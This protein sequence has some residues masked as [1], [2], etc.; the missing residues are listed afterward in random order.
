MK[1]PRP[2]RTSILISII[3]LGLTTC[4]NNTSAL[5]FHSD[6]PD[7]AD[8]YVQDC[9][10]Y[11]KE[12]NLKSLSDGADSLEL[13]IW[14]SNGLFI[15]DDHLLLIK[16]QDGQQNAF[17]YKFWR[18]GFPTRRKIDSCIVKSIQLK[19]GFLDRLKQEKIFDLPSPDNIPNFKYRH[20]DG[21]TW[22]IE[23]ATKDSYRFYYYT[24]PN[25]YAKDFTEFA[26][27]VKIADILKNEL[28]FPH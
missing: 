25:I 27:M 19:E 4:T 28:N 2:I 17:V 12:L 13:R 11:T 15:G 9:K 1:R 21:W 8:I 7:T 6:T 18:N 23:F 24:A 26:Q 14:Y 10:N 22:I 16:L 20:D 5:K 3:L